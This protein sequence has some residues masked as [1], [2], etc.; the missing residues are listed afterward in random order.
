MDSNLDYLPA[1][2]EGL[3]PQQQ[4]QAQ[5]SLQMEME[6]QRLLQTLAKYDINPGDNKPQ[7]FEE[8]G[9]RYQGTTGEYDQ[10]GYPVPKFSGGGKPQVSNLRQLVDVIQALKGLPQE[11]AGSIIS[12]LTGLPDP[13]QTQAESLLKLRDQQL[14]PQREALALQK[15]QHETSLAQYR[16][17][18]INL[19]KEALHNNVRQWI[20]TYHKIVET[21]SDVEMKKAA[22]EKLK[23]LMAVEGLL[24]A[25]SSTDQPPSSTDQPPSSG[26]THFRKISK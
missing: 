18:Q 3:S 8:L 13:S 22:K 23:Q 7:S 17:Q 2:L 5:Q 24:S 19:Q 10:G 12:K 20:E 1:S 14:Q 21:T 9:S 11:Y 16:E 6:K 26:V 4:M 15:Q 25:Q